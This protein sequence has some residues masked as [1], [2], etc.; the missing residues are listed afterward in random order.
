MNILAISSSPRIRGNTE[1]LLDEMIH[2]LNDAIA[3]AGRDSEYQIEKIRLAECNLMPCNQCDHCQKQGECP[4]QDD[5]TRMYP[6]LLA[7]DWFILASPI[8]FMAHCAQAKLLIDRCQ[9]FWAR[10]YVLK[11]SLMQPDQKFR[12]GVFISTGATHGTR[13]FSGA[14]ITM[15]WFLDALEMEYWGNLLFEGCDKKGSIHQHPT[16]LQDAYDLGQQII[17]SE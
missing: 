12:R 10:R 17:N 15:K 4:I 6:K 13:V 14:K 7:A 2:G 3:Q 11:Q 8:Y 5:I 1:T 16:A 9:T